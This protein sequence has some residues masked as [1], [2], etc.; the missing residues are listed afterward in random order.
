[1]AGFIFT[2]G[3]RISKLPALMTMRNNIRCYALSQPV[4][5]HKIFSNKFTI[6]EMNEFMHQAAVR[7][8]R[9]EPVKSF[10]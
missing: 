6:L 3:M 10:I 4:I 2:I 9:K 1:M 5:K 7:Q 8:I